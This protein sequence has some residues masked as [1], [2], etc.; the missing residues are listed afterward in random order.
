MDDRDVTTAR[1]LIV[2]D[3]PMNVRLLQRV[4]GV[5]GFRELTST[6]DSR[7]VVS[8]YRSVQP[9]LILL[10]LLM[11]HLDGVAVLEQ[12]RAE[13]PAE[14]FVPV[15]MLT[16]DVTIDAKRRA[17]S[18]GAHDFLTKPFEHFEVLLRIQNLLNTRRLHLILEKHN[19][20]LEATVRE[21]TERLLQSEKVGTM[22]SLLAGVAHELNNPLAALSGHAQLLR[23][24]ASDDTVIRR[25]TK[26]CDATDRCI[27]I[28]RNFLALARQRPPERQ[29]VSLNDVVRG[30]VELVAYELRTEDVDLRLDLADDVPVLHAD[31]HQLQQ[32]VVNLL[33]NAQHALRSMGKRGRIAI[34]SARDPNDRGLV[35]LDIA[36]SGPGIPEAIRLKIFEPFFTTKPPGEGTG[37]GLSL[38]REF[39]ESHGGSLTLDSEVGAGTRFII[40]LPVRTPMATTSV[41]ATVEIEEP[42]DPKNILVVDDE[43]DVAEVIAESLERDAHHVTVAKNGAV[44]L[45]LLA[46]QPWDLIISDT[47]MPVM[48]WEALWDEIQLRF[49]DLRGRVIFLTGDALSRSKADFLERAGAPYLL[50]PCD[51]GEMRQ[52]VRE[53]LSS[54]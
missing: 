5:A 11:P 53:T 10:D 46:Q 36:D 7:E 50:K 22:G 27:R 9:D 33:V 41:A 29:S 26:I 39:I 17:L 19:R 42:A 20:D 54:A 45:E 18:A 24:T 34:T 35:R 40:R 48:D 28:V 52:L 13:I 8:L 4:L 30:A 31:P 3:Q 2:D 38:C 47:K 49:P 16:A 44:A 25:A 14:A 6:T 51:L 21:R 43:T 1:I 15:L 37:L 32:V 23:N 12:L